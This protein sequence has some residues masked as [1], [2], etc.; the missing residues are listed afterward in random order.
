M[1][2]ITKY[3][4][5]ILIIAIGLIITQEMNID[6]K[7]TVTDEID[8]SGNRITNVGDPVEDTDGVN[9]LYVESRVSNQSNIIELSCG[10]STYCGNCNAE[11]SSCIP[12]DCPE[13][14]IEIS[15]SNEIT[16][17]S[18]MSTSGS[19][20]RHVYTVGNTTR[21]CKESE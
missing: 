18:V 7:L 4:I 20:D 21:V 14:W 8:V 9:A 5:A 2:N 1:K 19:S 11:I 17:V 12:P 16:G 15:E 13:G 10:W 6:G 3:T